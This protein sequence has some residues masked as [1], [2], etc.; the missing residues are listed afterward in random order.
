M[1]SLSPI[2][3]LIFDLDGTLLDTLAD[4]AHSVNTMLAEY[5]FPL[6]PMD[7]Y[8]W[9]IGEGLRMIVIR[10]LPEETRKKPD[11]VE[12]CV[13]RAR[14]CYQ[15]HWNQETRLYDGIATLLDAIDKTP[16]FKAILSNKPH[17]LTLRCVAHYLGR[18]HFDGVMGKT[19]QFPVKPNP[20]SALEIARQLGLL[21][22]AIIF[23]GDSMTDINTARA[24]GMAPVG[25]TWGFKGEKPLFDGGCPIL[26]RQAPELLD[27]LREKGVAL[28]VS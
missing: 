17:D 19:D 16:L 1:T 22:D 8:R 2:Q 28:P 5:G 11:L 10:A 26:V 7:D 18:W 12:K 21:P 25:V 14:E 23:V 20:A 4:I 27:I 13:D 3:G 15:N 6:H 24:A 9:F